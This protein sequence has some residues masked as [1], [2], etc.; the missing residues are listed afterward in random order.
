MEKRNKII[1]WIATGLMSALLILSSSLYF[2]N[3]EDVQATFIKLGYNDRIVIPLA[4]AKILAVAAIL[5]NKSK[6]LKEW[7]YFG[8]LVDFLLAIEAHLAIADG[9]QFGG[10]AALA[11]WIISYFYNKKVYGSV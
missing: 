2:I 11:L 10:I 4:I 6:V 3:L 9:E 8:L 5:S 1:F 7:A